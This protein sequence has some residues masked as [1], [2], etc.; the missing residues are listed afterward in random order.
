MGSKPSN[1][2][3]GIPSSYDD[4]GGGGMEVQIAKLRSD[5]DHINRE[6]SDIKI[7]VRE[8]RKQSRT[9]FLIT[10]G[11]LFGLAGLLAKGFGWI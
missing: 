11:G 7:D 6:V 5:V 2:L 10:W 8:I 3:K 1:F 4:G 9:D